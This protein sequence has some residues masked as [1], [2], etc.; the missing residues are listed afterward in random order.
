MRRR[1]VFQNVG[2]FAIQAV[3][4]GIDALQIACMDPA[5]RALMKEA[6]QDL[7]DKS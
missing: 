5:A 1:Q 4:G 7:L 3:G 2:S 6:A